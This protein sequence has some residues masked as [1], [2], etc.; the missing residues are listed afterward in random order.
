MFAALPM[1]SKKA[2]LKISPMVITGI[3]AVGLAALIVAGL[4]VRSDVMRLWPRSA[5]AYA[6]VGLAPNPAG[7]T[8]EGIKTDRVLKDGRAGLAVVGSIRNV[9]DRAKIAPP[10]RVTLTD[11]DGKPLLVQIGTPDG[12]TIPVGA[13]RYFS[14]TIIDPPPLAFNLDVDFVID[15]PVQT[16]PEPQDSAVGPEVGAVN[17]GVAKEVKPL[18]ANSPYALP[19]HAGAGEGDHAD[20]MAPAT[21]GQTEKHSTAKPVANGH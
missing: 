3:M 7:L 8:L 9:S 2:G 19:T 16:A 15:S 21:K 6:L 17:G 18:P 11:K 10:L 4:V 13:V 12:V 14:M 1:P 5:S 20:K